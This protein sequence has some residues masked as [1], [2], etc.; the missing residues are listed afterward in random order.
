MNSFKPIIK[1]MLD[2]DL[3]KFTMCQAVCEKYPH[4]QAKY[5]FINRGNTKF[6]IGFEKALQNQIKTLKELLLLKCEAEWLQKTCPFLT[7]VFI[8]FLMGYRY[9]PEEVSIQITGTGE[10]C[11]SIEGPWYRTILWEVKLMAIISELYFKMNNNISEYNILNAIGKTIRKGQAVT[12]NKLQVADFGTRRRA[13]E[14]HHNQIVRIL[15]GYGKEYFS[16]TSN[17]N[18]AYQYNIKPIGTQGHEWIMFHAA[19]YGYKEANRTALRK[20]VEVYHGNL[21]IAL[22]DTFTTDIFFKSFGSKY[23]KLF[24]GVRHDSGNP[25]DFGYNV[26]NHYKKLGID[27]M[28]KTIVFSDGLDVKSAIDIKKYCEGMISCSFGIG[29]FLTNQGFENSPPLNMVIK[30]WKINDFP[31]VK[32]SDNKGKE[33]GEKRAVENMKWIVE[34]SI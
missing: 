23:A 2:D 17:M 21:G 13:K 19:K 12:R 10:L 4:A 22:S 3:Y 16:G 26:I 34:Q 9:N 32:L 33:N 20:W 7:P 25:L 27:P 1:S 18:L 30:L 31:V 6:P 11:L 8:D 14:S 28:S 5:I 29:T 24:D 15:K